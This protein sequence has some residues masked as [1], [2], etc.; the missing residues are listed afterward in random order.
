MRRSPPDRPWVSANF[1]LT[2]DARISTRN[3]TPSDFSSREDKRRLLEIRS[4]ADAVLVSAATVASDRMTIGLP[5]PSLRAARKMRGQAPY[6]LRVLVTSS[7]RI[8]PSLPLFAKRFSRIIIFSTVR[9]PARIQ[10]ALAPRAEL[11]LADTGRVN[12]KEMINTLGREDG[13]ERL[14][15]EGGGTL[16]RSLLAEDLVDEIFL[17][18]C[19]RI[20]GGA[21]A[22]TLTGLAHEFL[23]HSVHFQIKSMETVGGECFLR[24]QRSKPSAAES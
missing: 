2:W 8:D 14:H 13:I 20:F 21:A 15:C 10:H 7:G 6:P 22:P 24:Y 19:P 11:R 1:A 5:S 12:L 3:R 18:L 4:R 23:P 9:M 16:L 17:T